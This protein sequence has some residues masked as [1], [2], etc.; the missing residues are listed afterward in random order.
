LSIKHF[1]YKLSFSFD[2]TPSF[3]G[4]I[5]GHF[6]I[7]SFRTFRMSFIRE[8][9]TALITCGTRIWSKGGGWVFD[10]QK[11]QGPHP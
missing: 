5:I 6:R 8:I 7:T 2:K 4:V 9:W 1:S 10:N 11:R 3:N